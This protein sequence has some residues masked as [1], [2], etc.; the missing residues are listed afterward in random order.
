MSLFDILFPSQGCYI[1]HREE[2]LKNGFCSQCLSSMKYIGEEIPDKID[3]LEKVFFLMEYTRLTRESIQRMKFKEET[4]YTKA[5]G[6]FMTE[7]ILQ[8]SLHEKIEAITFVPMHPKKERVRGY[9]QSKLLAKRISENLQIPFEN[10]L[11][12]L[13]NQRDQIGL[14]S[15]DRY[16]NVKNS[17]QYIG[18]E[19]Y[20]GVLLVDDVFTTGSTLEDC[21][22]ALKE[23][24]IEE[25]TG[26][27]ISKAKY[28]DPK[29]R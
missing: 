2:P 18:E 16:F 29:D 14:S 10:L 7:L 22:R 13:K 20:S 8:K 21:S 23:A 24:G 26:I 27:V 4:F 6:D 5:F 17:F 25:I 12:K 1:C 15:Y 3:Y 28:T 9:N 19:I 11:S